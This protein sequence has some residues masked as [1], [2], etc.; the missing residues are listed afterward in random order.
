MRRFHGGEGVALAVM[1]M[2]LA[3]AVSMMQSNT[4]VAA[5]LLPL[6]VPLA[7][8]VR[9]P[10][11]VL[12]AL[13]Y[14][15]TFGG[16][17]TPIGTPPN[18]IGYAAMKEHAGGMNFLSWMRVGIPIW[19]G[20]T[21]LA[22]VLFAV[23]G[24]SHGRRDEGTEA[25]RHGGLT[26]SPEQAGAN[27]LMFLKSQVSSP[28]SS[29]QASSPKPQAS[30]ARLWSI[31]AFGLAVA[32]WLTTGLLASI[33]PAGHAVLVWTQRYLPE[34]LPPILAAGLLYLVRVGPERKP[35]LVRADFQAVDWDTIFLIAGGLCLGKTLQASGAAAALAH[36]VGQTSL[37][38][39]GVMFALGAVTVA[40]SE[41]TSNTAT[42]ALLVPIAASL[43]PAVNMS[44][45]R[46]IWLVALC[47]SLGF[48]LPVSTPPN[49]IVYGTR[50]VPLRTM[51]LM[52]IMMDA[53]ALVWVVLC[54]YWMG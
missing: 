34:S 14:G 11:F 53:L 50:L 8:T 42:A 15:A 51:A 43:A 13:S 33:L 3:G 16:M 35:V 6:V 40:L 54:V 25:Q 18:F 24:R 5:M 30:S 9:R 47:A 38:P 36:A 31:A 10:A 27:D 44:P 46:T 22:C 21:A 26:A 17:A 1:V 45:V 29:P 4:A 48:A 52:G 37:P 49:A 41:L 19:A 7:R 12:L 2:L 23:M 20:T 32:I 28:K 39:L